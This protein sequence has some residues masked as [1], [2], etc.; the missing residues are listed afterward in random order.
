MHALNGF[1]K[2]Y[3]RPL[4]QA[5]LTVRAPVELLRQF[6]Q[7]LALYRIQLHVWN[8]CHGDSMHKT[9]APKVLE[10]SPNARGS[11]SLSKSFQQD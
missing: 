3:S 7:I 1:C 4:R 6:H 5:V 11:L 2:A 8:G 9:V 10:I